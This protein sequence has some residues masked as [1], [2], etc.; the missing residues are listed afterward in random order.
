MKDKLIAFTVLTLLIVGSALLHI[1]PVLSVLAI[2]SHDELT[3]ALG[4]VVLLGSIASLIYLHSLNG[5]FRSK[6][7]A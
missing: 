7:K 1:A 6:K 4:L 5:S 2:A 3:R